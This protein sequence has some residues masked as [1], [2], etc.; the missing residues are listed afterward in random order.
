MHP[1]SKHWHLIDYVITR[2]RDV[3][4]LGSPK[5]CVV[6]NA[7]WIRLIITKLNV[8]IQPPHQPQ[9]KRVT[10]RFIISKLQSPPVRQLLYADL[11]LKLPKLK[12][13]KTD[14]E[15]NWTALK[16]L[17]YSN[18]LHHLGHNKHKHQ[19]WFD[20]NNKIQKLLDDKYWAR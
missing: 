8:C 19:D 13:S 7:G 14:V 16:D 4:L 11:K 20:E 12:M 18:V 1:K 2:R 15:S 10:K 6:L 5:P 9:G 17:F 3:R